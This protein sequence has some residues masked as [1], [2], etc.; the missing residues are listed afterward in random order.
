MNGGLIT[1]VNEYNQYLLN[2]PSITFSDFCSQ[3]INPNSPKI[4]FKNIVYR[5]IRYRYS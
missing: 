1:L 4:T 3:R 5:K 2:N